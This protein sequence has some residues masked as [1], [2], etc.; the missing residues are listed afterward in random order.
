MNYFS[1]TTF[2]CTYNTRILKKKMNYLVEQHFCLPKYNFLWR[3]K[4]LIESYSASLQNWN[5]IHRR[6]LGNFCDYFLQ[7]L[8]KI[9]FFH[10]FLLSWKKL[11]E[12]SKR[13]SKSIFL[14]IYVLSK[15]LEN[16]KQK[17]WIDEVNNMFYSSNADLKGFITPP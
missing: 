1:Y 16:L 17:G 7:K 2:Q 12:K 6:F 5:R 15:N 14:K 4:N 9:I 11:I 10:N 8:L 3:L 13:Y